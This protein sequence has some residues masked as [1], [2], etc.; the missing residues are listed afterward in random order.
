MSNNIEPMEGITT[1]QNPP[2]PGEDEDAPT[3]RACSISK[4]SREAS[5]RPTP[6]KVSRSLEAYRG[7][8]TAT[9]SRVTTG[10]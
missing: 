6:R 9:I 3:G 7:V 2:V 4:A 8:E 10:R 5:P 1:S